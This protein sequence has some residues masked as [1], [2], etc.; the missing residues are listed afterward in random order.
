M[1]QKE[2]LATAIF[3]QHNKFHKNSN[4]I[5]ENKM[6]G[7]ILSKISQSWEIL[8]ELMVGNMS[9]KIASRTLK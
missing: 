1:S 8:S 2:I 6:K 3:N 5:Y 9:F 7:K 4:N